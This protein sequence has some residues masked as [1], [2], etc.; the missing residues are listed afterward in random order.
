[1]LFGFDNVTLL[2]MSAT[3]FAITIKID[4]GVGKP[5]S[6]LH[7]KNYN[8]KAKKVFSLSAVLL[9]LLTCAFRCLRRWAKNN[10]CGPSFHG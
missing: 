3:T 6:L 4:N 5:E 1:V 9:S 10:Y 7:S 2:E 8:A